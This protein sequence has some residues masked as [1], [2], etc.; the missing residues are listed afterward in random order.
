MPLP[1]ANF[2]SSYFENPQE[3]S[4]FKD[5]S[6]AS[7]VT[8]ST[9]TLTASYAASGSITI[10][11]TGNF[12]NWQ[13]FGI[14]RNATTG[15]QIFYYSKDNDNLY[16][17]SDGRAQ[18][19]TSAS[20]GSVSDVMH[21]AEV[22]VTAAL[23]NRLSAEVQ[24]LG[25][26]L[27]TDATPTFAGV[28]VGN[29]AITTN[30][31]IRY[32]SNNLE[33]RVNNS[34]EKLNGTATPTADRLVKA[35]SGQSKINNAWLKTGS[36]NGIDADMVDGQHASAFAAASHT[37]TISDITGSI[38]ADTLDGLDSSVFATISGTN[39][40]II[41]KAL[42]SDISNNTTDYSTISDL[43]LSVSG[44][45]MYKF[46]AT[47]FCTSS[48]DGMKVTI[49]SSAAGWSSYRVGFLVTPNVTT[50]NPSSH[51]FFSNSSNS[52]DM[53]VCTNAANF[54]LKIC[55]FIGSSSGSHDIRIQFCKNTNLSTAC[56]VSAQSHVTY[57]KF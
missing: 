29:S 20:A 23:L 25:L 51:W 33:A 55:G 40:N 50:S 32:S 49:S 5:G 53:F 46:D 8:V 42:G 39:P 11:S 45:I 21:F 18:N 54:V 22:R 38:N 4:T 6:N 16:V 14:V 26:N 1:S 7:D 17:N 57:Y 10:Q 12:T 30:G 24:A 36:G 47:L 37:H 15:E 35:E 31:T 34:W 19:G 2:P 9:A 27:K 28:T 48:S 44:T 41:T 56:Q 3:L 43:T 52:S 13:S